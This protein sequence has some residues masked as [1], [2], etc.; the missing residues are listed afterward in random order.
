MAKHNKKRNVG[1]IH[2]QLVKYASERTVERDT[3]KAN[4]AVDLIVKHFSA[5]SELLREFK[6]FGALIHTKARDKEQ[7]RRIIEESKRLC[8]TH[9]AS[10]LDREKTKL[11]HDI[12][13]N[14][15]CEGFY[16]QRILNYKLF[17]TVQT[18]INEW[19]GSNNLDAKE[20][21]DFE[22]HLEDHLLREFIEDKLE[23][24]ENADPLILKIMIEKFNNKY[25]SAFDDNQKKLLEAKLSGDDELLIEK[26]KNLKNNIENGLESFF[27]ECNNNVLL[28]KKSDV[29]STV[30]NFVPSACNEGL[31]KALVLANLLKEIKENER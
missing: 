25:G 21:V 18:L 28:S 20:I 31:A 13:V 27:K 12:N 17:A 6:L 15:N 2:E 24:K 23:K 11:I 7:A 10:K 14:L 1:L 9:N 5:Q 22:Q 16:D 4:E 29:I 19:R 3:N 26:M 8:Q 30:K